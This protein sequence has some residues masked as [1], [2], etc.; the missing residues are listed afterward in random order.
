MSLRL[1]I[2]ALFSSLAI[3]SGCQRSGIQA[4]WDKYKF[5]FDD[6]QKEEDHFA[7]FATL[8]INS[9]KKDSFKA[10]DRLFDKLAK[11]EVAYYVYT[12]WIDG[13]FY[14][15]LSPC[16]NADLYSK[17]VDRIVTDGVLTESECEQYKRKREWIGYNQTGTPATLPGV[18]VNGESVLVLVLDQGC[19]SCRLALNSLASKPEWADIRKIAICCGYGP[20][21][22]ADAWEFYLPPNASAVFDPQMTPV[23]F[24]VDEDGNVE[25][26]YQF[27]KY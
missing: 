22:A 19:P 18:S 17:A 25:T 27:V 12:S 24:V 1:Y 26:E 5:N 8:A 10:I 23:F 21:P 9:P 20:A 13:V 4:Y 14:S 3:L 2:I 7:D 6:I 11:D 16:R 15:V